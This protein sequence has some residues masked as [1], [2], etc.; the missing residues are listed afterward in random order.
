MIFSSRRESAL[1]FARSGASASAGDQIQN[2]VANGAKYSN[3]YLQ[4]V[5]PYSLSQYKVWLTKIAALEEGFEAADI[6]K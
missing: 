1:T 3:H 6:G 2:S 5:P 4:G